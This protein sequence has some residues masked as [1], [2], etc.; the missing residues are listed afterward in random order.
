[1]SKKDKQF[2]KLL[3]QKT[4]SSNEAIQLLEIDGWYEDPN[5]PQ[6]G[7]HKQFV[8]PFK[9]GKVTVPANRKS[10]VKDTKDDI[11]MQAGL[12]GD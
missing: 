9:K 7:S 1:M 3:H 2:Q 10:L 6:N 11:L 12:M 4:L 8:H 5:N